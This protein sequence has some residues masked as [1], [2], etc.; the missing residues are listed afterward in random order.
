MAVVIDNLQI[1]IQSE[2][3]KATSSLMRLIDALKDL[4]EVCK[5]GAGL[6]AVVKQLEKLNK[7]LN[8]QDISNSLGNVSRSAKKATDDVK[9]YAMALREVSKAQKE[10][11]NNSLTKYGGINSYDGGTQSRIG[12]SSMPLLGAPTDVIDVE[13]KEISSGISQTGAA[14]S[15]LDSELERLNK[16]LSYSK[17]AIGEVNQ[18]NINMLQST[19]K[20]QSPLGRLSL[21]FANIHRKA[22]GAGKSVGQLFSS[23]K[24][25]AM[26]RLLRTALKEIGEAFSEGMSNAYQYSK[27]VGT[28]LAPALDHLASVNLKMKNQLGAFAGQL[29]ISIMPMLTR[30]IDLVTKLAD[31]FTEIFAA[32][33]GNPTYQKAKDISTVWEEATGAVK[34]Y[35]QQ[36]L[37]LDELNILNTDNK[38]IGSTPSVEDMFEDVPVRDSFKWLGKFKINFDDILFDWDMSGDDVLSKFTDKL[39]LLVGGAIG[40]AFGGVGGALIGVVSAAAI[41]ALIKTFKTE[42]ADGASVSIKSLGLTTVLSGLVGGLIGFKVGG[43]GG[44][45]IGA[46]LTMA[47][48]SLISTLKM[49]DATH[50]DAQGVSRLFV[51]VLSAIAGAAIGF[52]AGG[53]GGAAIGASIGLSLGLLMSRLNI[54]NQTREDDQSISRKICNILNTATSGALGAYIGFSVGGIKGAIMGLSLGTSLSLILTDFQIVDKIKDK[55]QEAA[56]SYADSTFGQITTKNG[57]TINLSPSQDIGNAISNM[58]SQSSSEKLKRL[59]EIFSLKA[60]GGYVGQGTLFYAGEAGPEFVGSMGGQ[61]AVANTDQMGDAIRQAA[62]EGMSQAL[63]EHGDTVVLSPDADKIFNITRQKGREYTRRTGQS[64]AY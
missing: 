6:G 15:D 16:D 50:Q 2:S 53:L 37:G 40:F 62:Y 43:P 35:K 41:T 44:A 14:V 24:R 20:L 59:G 39:N 7:V 56:K 26:Y 46:T 33:N 38:G 29:M 47:L 52:K 36:L 5:G 10:M 48:T 58:T 19:L 12:G 9:N 8:G 34:E 1:E 55:V 54:T 57:S 3:T 28:E 61:T 31:R 60:D 27:I 17:M 42:R 63:R 25:I 18:G 11:S 32:L 22:S 51:G 64:W 49:Q 30:L 45:I 21:F 23:L 4:R 13:W